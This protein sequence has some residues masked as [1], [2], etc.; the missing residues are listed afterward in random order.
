VG[1]KD[2]ESREFEQGKSNIFG[3]L[4]VELYVDDV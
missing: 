2:E 1:G 4:D 3:V